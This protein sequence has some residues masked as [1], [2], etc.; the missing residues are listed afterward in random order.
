MEDKVVVVN[1]L[2]RHFKGDYYLVEKVAKNESDGSAL[3]IYT[4]VVTGQ[5][6]VRPYDEFF[7]D[8]SDREDNKTHQVYRFEPASEI[9]GL[10]KLIPT[11]ELVDE[12]ETREDSPYESCKKLNDDENVWNVQYLIGRVVEKAD[13]NTGENYEEF[14]PLTLAAFDTP[15][16]AKKYRERCYPNRPAILARRVTR[17]IAEL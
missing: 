11:S 17:K 3:V 7:T 9:K 16:S 10:I 4:S 15:E 2:Y 1:T 14:V 6:F 12:L 5:T 8:I 13:P